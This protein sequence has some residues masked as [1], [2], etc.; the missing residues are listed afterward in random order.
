MTVKSHTSWL[1][2]AVFMAILVSTSVGC[3][4][5]A[6]AEAE[7]T[8]PKE[9]I[10][11]VLVIAPS[12]KSLGLTITEGVTLSPE[13]KGVIT[14]E[15]TAQLVKWHVNENQLV[16]A[17]DPI[18]TL[19]PID[20]RISLAQANSGLAALE[21]QYV[22]VE[23][24]FGR[25]QA[26]LKSGSIP[27]SQFDGIQA[28]K[29]ALEKQVEAAKDNVKMLQRKLAK[30]TVRAPFNGVIT[31]KLAPLGKYVMSTM[32]GGGDIAT[33]EK[34]DR[35]KA[36]FAISEMFFGEI[37]QGDAVEF[38]IPTLNRRVKAAIDSKG[39]SISAM[40]TFSLIAY[41]DNTEGNIPAG[42]F[43]MATI[44]TPERPR[45]IVPST[46]VL[47]TG[48]RMGQVFTIE[49]GIVTP[50]AVSIGFTFEEG[51]EVI[52]DIPSLVI[53]DISSIKSGEAV[54]AVEA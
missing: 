11:E 41:I 28:Q 14:S 44:H 9:V 42:V 16:K 45:V 15:V 2:I 48:N 30:A 31:G 35:L 13:E 39:K 50:R 17:G 38:Y 53:K 20:Y 25:M 52:G 37:K 19:D 34:I 29:T 4:S 8:T 54:E 51:L 47:T 6:G 7:Q 36:S 10:K 33:I 32:P 1:A 26:L 27:Q 23:K 18:A 5:T 24:D 43:A 3:R 22:S 49:N 46:A 12:T 21:A 40:K